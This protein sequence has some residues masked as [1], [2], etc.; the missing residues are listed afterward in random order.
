[1]TTKEKK[2]RMAKAALKA[3]DDA[4]AQK[5]INELDNMPQLKKQDTIKRTYEKITR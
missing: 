4:L 3:G 2:I 5:L 1:M